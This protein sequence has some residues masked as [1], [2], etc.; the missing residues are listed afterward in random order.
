MSD[1]LSPSATIY[2]RSQAS[3]WLAALV[4]SSDD[5]IVSKT[6][7]GLVTTWNYGAERTYGYLAHEMIGQPILKIIPTD[8][9]SEEAT[10]LGRI[11]RGER[12]DHFETI[13]L[14]KDGTLINVSVTMS[15]VRDDQGRI[16]GVSKIARDIT[17]Q[18]R[19][20]S[21]LMAARQAAEAANRAKDHFLGVLSHELRTPLNPVLA[22]VSLLETRSDLP[23]DVGETLQ[24]I[25]RNIETEAR[26][27]DDLLDITRIAHGKITLKLQPID[28]H[29]VLRS[30]VG[31]FESDCRK[32]N[33]SI[34]F[35]LH[36]SNA[37]INV[38]PGRF[39]QALLNILSNAVKFT[40]DDGQV[41]IRTSNAAGRLCIEIADNG[42]GIDPQLLPRLFGAF[43]QGNHERKHRFGGL[44]LGLS[45]AKSLVDLHQGK[46]T[47]SSEG[48][49]KGACF[50]FEFATSDATVLRAPLGPGI[51]P[52]PS[53]RILLVEDHGDTQRVMVSLLRGFGH[54]V[55]TA[56]SVAQACNTIDTQTIDL[57][58]CDIG[59]PDGSGL[60]VVRRLKARS[61]A[62]A[63]AVTGYG[64][65][66]DIQR[67][68]DAGFELHVTKPISIDMLEKAIA[69]ALA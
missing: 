14:R 52:G 68:R 62:K 47:A 60:D 6:L 3:A 30:V 5:A 41:S 22:S 29:A 55:T 51:T 15:P 18:K 54:T 61:P 66:E 23:A 64:Y 21:D 48:V 65:E 46:L 37:K 53:Q 28:A 42:V 26:L 49:G 10:I 7:D 25:R 27:V 2:P 24:I 34:S 44:G 31:M 38:D 69:D 50:S 57:L 20:Q 17:Q 33:Q 35:S 11:S 4:D 12:I 67:S 32:R 56:N 43:E 13:R 9:H 19:Y 8:R 45:I 59:L 16:I 39:Q 58:I 40:P 36:A 63:I 1:P